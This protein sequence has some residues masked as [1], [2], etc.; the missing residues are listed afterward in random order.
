MMM[1]AGRIALKN[2]V[3]IAVVVFVVMSFP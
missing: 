3:S 1:V 2:V